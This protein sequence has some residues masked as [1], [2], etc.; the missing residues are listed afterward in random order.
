MITVACTYKLKFLQVVFYKGGGLR[1]GVDGW[2]FGCTN[3]LQQDGAPAHFCAIVRTALVD[4]SVGEATQSSLNSYGL[5]SSGGAV[6]TPVTARGLNL[7][8]RC[9]EGLQRLS[10]QRLWM[11]CLECRVTW[12]FVSTSVRPSVALTLNCTKWQKNLERRSNSFCW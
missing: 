7:F 9:A 10:L 2:E 8:P 4:G 3:L 12:S 11:C 1:V 6:Q 5:T